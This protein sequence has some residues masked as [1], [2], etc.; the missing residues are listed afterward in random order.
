VLALGVTAPAAAAAPP[1]CASSQLSLKFVSFQGATGHR[2]WQL[3]FKNLGSKCSLRGFPR[4]RLLDS[5]GH[6]I[7][8]TIK[9]ETGPVPTVVVRHGRRAH[10]TFSYTDGAFCSKHFHAY[11]IKVFPPKNSGGFIFNPVPKNFGPIFVCRGSARVSP[12]RAHPDG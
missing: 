2:F 1:H 7:H 3:A 4:V 6:R 9:H 12:V 5:H 11:R 10:F 8:T